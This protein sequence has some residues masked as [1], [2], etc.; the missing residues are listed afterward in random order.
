[1]HGLHAHVTMIGDKIQHSPSDRAFPAEMRATMARRSDRVTWAGGMSRDEA[2]L[3]TATAN[4]GVS[5]RAGSLDTSL[6]ISTKLLEYCALGVPPLLNRTRAH[7]RLLGAD[8]PMFVEDDVV[9]ALVRACDPAT[10]QD[11]ARR[12]H[13]AAQ[14]F[15]ASRAVERLERCF[16][17]QEP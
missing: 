2:M 12:A 15:R 17:S 3:R 16:T 6:E 14:Y 11:A 1:E 10:R 9:D 7:E 5:W 8:Y 13:A 4:V